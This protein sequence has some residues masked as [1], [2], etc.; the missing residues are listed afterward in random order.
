MEHF[1]NNNV[2]PYTPASRKQQCNSDLPKVA[3]V[4][5]LKSEICPAAEE[6]TEM[7]YRSANFFSSAKRCS[8]IPFSAYQVGNKSGDAKLNEICGIKVPSVFSAARN[9]LYTRYTPRNWFE[10]YHR[11]LQANDQ[12]Q[13]N[14]ECFILESKRLEDELADKAKANQ[15]NSTR[16]L[17]DRICDLAFWQSELDKEI[18]NMKKEIDDLNCARKFVEKFLAETENYLHITQECLYAREKRQGTDLVHDNVEVKLLKVI[19]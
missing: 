8:T 2:S 11:L 10:S 6:D 17:G 1:G 18:G 12:A 14:S 9:A 16:K 5:P 19:F 3:S 15:E 7:H 4:S 13:K